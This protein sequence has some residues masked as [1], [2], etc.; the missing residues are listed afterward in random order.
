MNINGMTI[1][2]ALLLGTSF[3]ALSQEKLNTLRLKLSRLKLLIV[4]EISMVGS[5]L[6]L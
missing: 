4:D 5:N 6:L 2:S 3:H 1:H